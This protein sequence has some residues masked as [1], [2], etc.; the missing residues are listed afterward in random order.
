MRVVQIADWDKYVRA[1]D[2]L[3]KVG[4]TFQGRPE[5]VLLVTDAQYQALVKAKVVVPNGTEARTDGP[6][7][8][9]PTNP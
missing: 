1:F 4:G 3:I 7:A 2:V 9:K 8:K 5:Q 6:P